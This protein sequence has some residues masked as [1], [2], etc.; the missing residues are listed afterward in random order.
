MIINVAKLAREAKIKQP[1]LITRPVGRVMYS[2]MKEKLSIAGPGETIILDFQ[3]IKVID[4]SFIDEFLVKL[5]NDSEDL[6][7]YI[8]LRN[9]SGISEINIDYV[10]NSYS[11][12]KEGRLAVIR[13]D[14]GINNRYYIGPLTEHESD[15][16]DYLKLNHHAG[17]DE[18]A[19]FSG[20]ET[21]V[22]R[23]IIDDLLKLRVI[24]KNDGGFVSV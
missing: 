7:F 22:I 10:F 5:I 12:Y 3:N 15:I 23:V 6:D 21:G 13:E 18:M 4:S 11:N 8:K 14:L 9:I 24:R 1:D 17:I 2:K 19:K 16:I 20:M